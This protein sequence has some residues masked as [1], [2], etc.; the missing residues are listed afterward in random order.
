MKIIHFRGDL[1]V[2][3]M[4]ETLKRI[5]SI[6]IQAH[7]QYRWLRTQTHPML[8]DTLDRYRTT[9]LVPFASVPGILIHRYVDVRFQEYSIAVDT[10]LFRVCAL[11]W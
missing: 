5:A 3:I 1:T 8:L 2:I 7:K 11:D 10:L 6:I 9:F 4:T